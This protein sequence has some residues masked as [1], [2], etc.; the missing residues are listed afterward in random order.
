[1]SSLFKKRGWYYLQYYEGG[2]HVCKALRTKEKWVARKH[3]MT[4]DMG[5]KLALNPCAIPISSALEDFLKRKTGLVAATTMRR[6]GNYATHLVEFF[7]SVGVE[8]VEALTS[9]SVNS[10][11]RARLPNAAS[12]TVKEEILFLKMVISD[13]VENSFIDADPVRKWPSIKVRAAKP[14]S[15]GPYS[16]EDLKRLIE[17]FRGKEFFDVFLGAIYTGCRLDELAKL[18]GADYFPQDRVLKV[19]STK[20]EGAGEAER[21]VEVHPE[22]AAI[23]EARAKGKFLFPEMGNHGYNWGRRQMADACKALGIQYRRFHGLRHS[24]GTYLLDSGASIMDTKDAMGQDRIV[25]EGPGKHI[26]LP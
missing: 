5:G 14:E 11:A 13:L 7:G 1:M 2:K 20:T 19:R 24:F 8:S 9:D 3:Q 4:H 16:S 15:L 26:G 17:H 6:Y 18:K 23:F 10:Y 22:L 25:E 12:K 21:F